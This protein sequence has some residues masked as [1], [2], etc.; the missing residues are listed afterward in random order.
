MEFCT[1]VYRD[2]KTGVCRY[3]GKGNVLR[4]LRHFHPNSDTQ[5]S[6][7]LRKRRTEGFDPKPIVLEASSDADACEMEI[8]LIAMIGR[9]DLGTGPLFNKT[10][11]GDGGAGRVVK[12]QELARRAVTMQQKSAAEKAAITARIQQTR[13]ATI[14]DPIWQASFSQAVALGKSRPCTVDGITIYPSRLELIKAL[15]QGK[16]GGSRSPTFRY[17]N[18]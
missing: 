17:I 18:G 6:R 16:N 2:P 7:L 12:P 4:P 14:S 15:G 1:Y 3:V 10:A 11:G 13:S 5:L 8:L 9:E